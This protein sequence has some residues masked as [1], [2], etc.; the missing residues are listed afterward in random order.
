MSET[1]RRCGLL[2]QARWPWVIAALILS[3]H[4]LVAYAGGPQQVPNIYLTLGLRRCEVLSGS[5]WQLLTYAW[6]HGNGWHALINALGVLILGGRVEHLLG[7]RGFLTALAGGV[8]GGALGHLL[9]ADGGREAFPLVGISGACV[10]LLLVI[11]TLSPQS[12]MLPL[13]VSG[14][15][16]GLGI[17]IA[18][19]MLA[20]ANPQLGLPGLAQVGQS[21]VTH[22][23]GGWF[24]IGHACQLGGGVAGWLYARW[25][26]RPG[27]TLQQLR[28]QRHRREAGQSLR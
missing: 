21:L 4:G 28:Q 12:R 27:P 24:A 19:L 2:A 5:V 20:L 6:L 25:I 26:L 3:I 13:P 18:A 11:T 15:S 1:I 10:A 14:R 9:L 7:Q 16:L 23:L 22:G 17:L 8:I